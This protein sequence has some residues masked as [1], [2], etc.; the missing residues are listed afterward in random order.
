METPFACCFRTTGLL[1]AIVVGAAKGA[2]I[3]AVAG[4]VLGTAGGAIYAGMTGANMEESI[5]SGFLM[6]FGIGAI[7]GAVIGGFVGYVRYTPMQISGFTRHGLNQV[8]SRDGHG[9]AN[10]A[11]LETMKTARPVSQG[12]LQRSFKFAGQNAV[13]ILNKT[14]KVITAWAKHKAARRFGLGLLWLG[15]NSQ[16]ESVN[17]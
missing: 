15:L 7:I 10:K 9:V 2:L 8:I 17:Y 14:G 6:G 11:I 3:G 4:S 5:L 12:F 1:G 13:V 16:F